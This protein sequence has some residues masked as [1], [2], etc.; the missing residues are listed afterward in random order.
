MSK[1]KTKAKLKKQALELLQKVVRLKA[2]NDN[3]YCECVTCGVIKPWND[4]MQGG[5]FISK[6]NGGSNQWALVEENVHPQCAGCNGFGMRFGSAT[7][8]Y[9]LYMIDTYGR[10]LVDEMTSQNKI[11]RYD[12][13]DLELM[14]EEMKIEI[15]E[16]LERIGQ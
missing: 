5:H 9:T 6:G 3:G 8:A 12:R 14:I 11:V 16:Q 1:P 4:G 2:A 10:E 15:K 7:Q 13:V